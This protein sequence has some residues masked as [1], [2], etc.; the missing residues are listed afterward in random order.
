MNADISLDGLWDFVVDLDPK[1]HGSRNYARP[2]WDRRHWLKVPVP[3]VWNR[4]AER[5]DIFE[6]VGWFAR[7]FTVPSL[8]SGSTC[9]LRFG[10]VNYACE[11]FLNG[12]LAGSHEGGYTEFVLDV[13]SLVRPGQNS[14]AVRVE[15]RSLKMK[16]PPVLGYFNYGG[17]HRDVTLEVHAGPYLED[18][19]YEGSPGAVGGRLHLSG[20]VAGTGS[21]VCQ[22]EATCAGS[23]DR[24]S[25]ATGDRF[26]LE[27]VVPGAEAWSP[28]RPTL[29]PVQVSLEGNGQTCQTCEL[30]I[31]FRTITAS[32]TRIELNGSPLHFRGICYLYDSPA[33]GL[34]MRPEQYEH[35]LALLREFP[36]CSRWGGVSR[37][38]TRRAHRM[39]RRRSRNQ[40]SPPAS[41]IRR[42]FPAAPRT[43][44][45]R[46]HTRRCK[47]ASRRA[48]RTAHSWATLRIPRAC[49]NRCSPGGID[50]RTLANRRLRRQPLSRR[51]PS[52]NQHRPGRT[53]IP[54]G[55]GA[56]WVGPW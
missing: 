13:S 5:Y 24:T 38:R 9:L 19:A 36:S 30:E 28:D 53:R 55:T 44:R 27:L 37:G 56:R 16:L 8:E 25:A 40:G 31:G 26:D 41:C 20:V 3:G 45:P 2:G 48:P 6:G 51:F 23:S 17:I 46:T 14:I 54:P 42:R 18:L 50:S 34:V 22:V 29:Y 32:G 1:Y 39:C 35:D 7:E 21:S 43:G 47:S 11:V 4:Y 12:E 33:Y 15:N 10:G 49:Q 52:S